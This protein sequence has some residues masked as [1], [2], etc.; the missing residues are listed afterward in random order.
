MTA[1]PDDDLGDP[2]AGA[3]WEPADDRRREWFEAERAADEQRADPRLLGPP[4]KA[5]VSVE[6]AR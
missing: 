2:D 5:E 6:R 4:S 3:L 1:N